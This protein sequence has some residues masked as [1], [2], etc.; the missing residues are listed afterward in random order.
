MIAHILKNKNP[1]AKI[2][3]LDPKE[4]FSKQG[5]FMEGWERHYPGMVEWIPASISGGVENINMDT[6]EIVTDIDTFKA[7]AA[8]VVPAQ[9]AGAICDRA[10]ITDGD[11][12]P[13]VP[14]TMQSRADENIHVLGD[15]SVAS[16]MPKSGFS[17]NSQAKVAANA[18]RGALTGSRVFPARFA[19]T[20]WSLIDDNDG[21]K[22]GA[23]YKAGEEK[24]EAV[25]TFVSKT[26]EDADLRK[27]TYEES[28]AWYSA[29]TSDMFS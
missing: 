27:A 24:I 28:E 22:V 23:N 16:A 7:D 15:A 20:C 2:V 12:C 9:K 10:G 29:I 26:G 21:I 1:T 14:A 17:A 13:I 18:I 3:V 4:K 6:M 11:W 25:D 8:S 5:L 19:N